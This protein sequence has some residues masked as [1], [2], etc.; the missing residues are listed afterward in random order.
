MNTPPSNADSTSTPSPQG[1]VELTGVPQ[2]DLVLGGGIPKGA[3]VI[4]LG[5]PGSGKTTLASQVAFAAAR[6]GEHALLLTALSEPTTKLLN[7]LQ[8]YSFYSADLVGSNVQVFSLQQFL[9]QGKLPTAQEV[10]GAVRQTRANLVVLDGF[11]GIRAL[12]P[13]FI[14]SR[15]LLYDLGTRLSLLGTTTLITTE[16]DPRDSTLFPEM[17]TGDVLIGLYF[18]LAGGRAFRSLEVLKVRGRAPLTGRHSFSLSGQGVH[19][20]PRLESWGQ[21]LPTR[22]RETEPSPL[23]QD[24]A[25]FGLPELDKLLGGGLTRKT[26]TLLAGSLGAGKTLLALQFAL[27]SISQ[28][29]PA[30]FLGFRETREQLLQKAS[31][32]D[33]GAQFRAALEPGG[34]LFLQRWEPVD[35]DPDQVATNLLLA[36]EQTGARRVVI[37]SIAE[38]ER[39]V[40]ESSGA[41]RI[42]NYLAALLA[43]FRSYGVTLLAI[44]ETSKMVATSLDF[45]ADPLSILA[46]NVLLAQQVISQDQL[47]RVI[48][49]V[50]MR[51]SSHEHSLRE[52]I[53]APPDGLRVLTPLESGLDA[54]RG[55]TIQAGRL[56]GQEDL[57]F[58]FYHDSPSDGGKE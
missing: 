34:G 47:H 18:T 36:L 24:R 43:V 56:G 32:F 41:E 13:D 48:S 40:V 42:S 30:L 20:Y 33:L 39:A 9:T 8:S 11:Q 23:S 50:K 6:R 57:L 15:Q 52:F 16:A 17:T 53:I 37:D 51:F 44:K 19:V 26:S 58:P 1:R 35:V 27:S 4:I 25:T 10:V 49:V 46:E 14:T 45:S 7:H 2:L 21:Y 38:L 5:A 55:L 29:E 54:L 31:A 12:E 3:L 28:G 22:K